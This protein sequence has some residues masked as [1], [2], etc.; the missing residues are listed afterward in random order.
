VF[1]TIPHAS[2]P[3]DESPW[4]AHFRDTNSENRR[5]Q[6]RAAGHADT[7]GHDAFAKHIMDAPPGTNPFA[8]YKGGFGEGPTGRQVVPYQPDELYSQYFGGYTPPGGTPGNGPFADPATSRPPG[9]SA[10][11]YGP[12]PGSSPAGAPTPGMPPW[13]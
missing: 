9:A 2:F 7:A 10:S 12:A 11:P 6:M 8:T 13:R 5:A 4:I 3:F 1:N